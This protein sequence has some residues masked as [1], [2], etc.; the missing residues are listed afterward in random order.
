MFLDYQIKETWLHK[1]NPSIKLLFFIFLFIGVLFIHNPNVMLNFLFIVIFLLLFFTGH[2]SKYVLLF[3]LPFLLL[4]VSS[5]TSMMFFG[6]GDTTW[7]K[8]G[9]VHITEES[10]FRGLHIGMRALFFAIL[11]LI[12][13]LTTRPAYLFYSLMQQLKL[14]AKYAYSFMAAIRLLPIMFEE[15]QTLRHALIVRGVHHRKGIK[16]FYEKFRFYAIPLLAQSIRRAQRIAVAMEAK[17]FSQVS[18]R[19]YY[20]VITTSKF[21]LF[22]ILFFLLSLLLGFYLGIVQPYFQVVDV[23]YYG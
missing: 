8:W 5:S 19:S 3:F 11:G 14:P 15:I 23:R 18:E 22:L 17:R 2:P 7:F 12:F 1:A 21:D 16:G 6:K 20:Y 13:A 4:F 9:L 10:F